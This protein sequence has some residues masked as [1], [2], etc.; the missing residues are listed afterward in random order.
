MFLA[1]GFTCRKTRSDQ[2][3]EKK[4]RLQRGEVFREGF[5]HVKIQGHLHERNF[6]SWAQETAFT[7]GHPRMHVSHTHLCSGG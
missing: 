6:L 2:L 1:A 4:C 5:F 3:T 7:L